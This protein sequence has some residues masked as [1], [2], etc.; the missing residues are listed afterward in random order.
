MATDTPIAAWKDHSSNATVVMSA[1]QARALR[2]YIDSLDL[3]DFTLNPGTYGYGDGDA[4][5]F[6]NT[7]GL[8]AGALS[9]L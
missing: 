4:A 2:D 3:S 6:A 9:N 1:D 8:L 5:D 7:L